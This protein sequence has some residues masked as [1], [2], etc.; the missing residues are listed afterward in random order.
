M[1]KKGFT[2]VEIL[3]V[4][5]LIGGLMLLIIP[6][7]ISSFRD[8]KKELF[9]DNLMKIYDE[10]T[11]TYLADGTTKRFCVGKDTI[12]RQLGIDSSD[13]YY[14]VEVDKYGSVISIKVTDGDFYYSLTSDDIIKKSD[15]VKSE[16]ES[17]NNILYC[18]SGGYDITFTDYT[19]DNNGTTIP[20]ATLYDG[21]GTSYEAVITCDNGSKYVYND[22]KIDLQ[23]LVVP[24]YCK[25]NFTTK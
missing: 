16:I 19:L 21:L 9:Y 7:V 14:D 20:F 3:A 2:L 11:N 22:G 17:G 8:A 10:A 13:I 12:I 18:Y 15:I 1:Y 23:E 24:D 5:V 6:N 25:I 4:I